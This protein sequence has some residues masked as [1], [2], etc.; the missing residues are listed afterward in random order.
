MRGTSW[1]SP[2][3]KRTGWQRNVRTITNLKCKD[4]GKLET[5]FDHNPTDLELKRFGGREWFEQAK[6]YGVELDEDE[7][8]YQIGLLYSGRG[9]YNTAKKYFEKIKDKSMLKTLIEDF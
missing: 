8:Y 6:E 7:N 9:D 5:V 3:K 2:K 4:M 1:L